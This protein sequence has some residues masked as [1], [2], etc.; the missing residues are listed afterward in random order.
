MLLAPIKKQTLIPVLISFLEPGP[1][2]LNI[3]LP[4][5]PHHIH[6]M[7]NLL[8]LLIY[9]LFFYHQRNQRILSNRLT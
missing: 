4:K 9:R 3:L 5:S 1:L 8:N 6:I 2:I 7:L